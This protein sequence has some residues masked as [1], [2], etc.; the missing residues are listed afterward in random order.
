MRVERAARHEHDLFGDVEAEPE[1]AR[2]RS[3]ALSAAKGLCIGAAVGWFGSKIVG[4]S[5]PPSVLADVNLGILAA[6]VGGVVTRYSLGAESSYSGVIVSLGG[7]L[8]GSCLVIF[9]WRALS[10]R[11]A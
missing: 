2:R 1:I 8:F 11:R 6:L 3:L 4:T 10:R 7:A 5:A 9:G